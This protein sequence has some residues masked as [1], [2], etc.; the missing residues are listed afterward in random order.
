MPKKSPK[1]FKSEV[2]PSAVSAYLLLDRSG[3]MQHRMAEAVGSINA[4]AHELAKSDTV[5]E[6]TLCTFD[7]IGGGMSFD[8]IRRRCPASHWEPVHTYEVMPRGGTPLYD[9]IDRI[10]MAAEIEGCERT[11]IAIMTDGYENASKQI[12]R[13]KAKT[14]LDKARNRGWQ[15]IFFGADFDAFNQASWVGSNYHQTLNVNQGHY[16]PAMRSFAC[17]TQSYG[18][19][20]QAMSFTEADRKNAGGNL[21]GAVPGGTAGVPR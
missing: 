3:S 2:K 7:E 5:A 9:A 8:V 17:S 21:S 10:A 11:V 4:Y 16:A 1:K 13:E 14:I 15:V 12:N 18:A 6:I 19:T 20:G